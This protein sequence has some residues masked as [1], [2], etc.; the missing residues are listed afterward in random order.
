[1]SE[2][3]SVDSVPENVVVE[4]KIVR[5]H[6]PIPERN[7]GQK[8]IRRDGQWYFPTGEPAGLYR[9]THWRP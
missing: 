2:W 8:M 1:M 3:R 6:G 5:T 7:V 9:A 4:T